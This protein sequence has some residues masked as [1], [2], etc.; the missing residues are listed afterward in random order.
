MSKRKPADLLILPFWQ[1]SKSVKGAHSECAQFSKLTSESIKSGDFSGKEGEL[2][3]LYPDSLPEKRLILLGLGN[4]KKCGLETL[5]RTFATVTKACRGKNI[6]SLHVLVPEV[7][8]FSEEAIAAAIAEG[9]SLASYYFDELKAESL[10]EDKMY[11]VQRIT[12]LGVKPSSLAACQKVETVVQA[13]NAARDLV[14][15]N[16]DQVNPENIGKFAK[17]LEKEYKSIKT[18]VLTR[19]EIEKN[20]MGLLLA[21]SRGASCDPSFS[22]IEYKGNPRSKECTA[23]VGKGVTYDTGG[24]NLKPTGGIETMKCDM[25]GAAAVLGTM[26]AIAALGLKVNVIG[27][28]PSTE[29]AIG[30]VSFKPGDVYP[31]FSGKTVEIT[32][33]DAEGRLI[34]ADAVAYVEKHFS[35]KYIIDLATLTGA[36]VI[37]LGEE[38]TGFFTNDDK[39]GK[40]LVE[41]GDATNELLWRMPLYPEYKEKLR[42]TIA[43]LKNWNGRDAGSCVAATFIQQFMNDTPWAHL[44]IAGT[45]YLS[46]PKL[47][48]NTNATGVGIRLLVNFFEKMEK[49]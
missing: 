47:Y 1:E 9:M 36:M 28:I 20:K 2:L 37:S 39:L 16:A 6:T 10:K 27:A 17:S 12:L 3:V 31:S 26:K 33:T 15:R 48:H 35:P 41:S 42:S 14:N 4:A 25:A 32:N 23:I 30:P 11:R 44:D 22:I 21:V 45:A 29:N 13:V 40:A 38:A 49:N 43:D 8:N 18:T 19:S 24:L 34:L 7:T 46:K 5:R